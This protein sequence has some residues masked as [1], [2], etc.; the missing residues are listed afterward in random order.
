[1]LALISHHV[2][3]VKTARVLNA[4][5]VLVHFLS[6]QELVTL[7][8]LIFFYFCILVT[9]FSDCFVQYGLIVCWCGRRSGVH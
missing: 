2:S 3:V 4:R 7:P 8:V 5:S 9:T 6:C 1:M